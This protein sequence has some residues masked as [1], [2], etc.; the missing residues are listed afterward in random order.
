MHIKQM[1]YLLKARPQA[2]QKA[3]RT[4]L[5]YT[6]EMPESLR[7]IIKTEKELMEDFDHF[8]SLRNQIKQNII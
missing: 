8:L 4:Y 7:D 3:V 5:R 1:R 2:E 6:E